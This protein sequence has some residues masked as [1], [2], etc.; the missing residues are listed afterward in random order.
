MLEYLSDA[1]D[2]CRYI[3]LYEEG[4][5][6]GYWTV[7]PDGKLQS[8]DRMPYHTDCIALRTVLAI[9]EIFGCDY[10]ISYVLRKDGREYSTAMETLVVREEQLSIYELIT[11]YLNN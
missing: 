7:T 10:T 1:K 9:S 5:D 3:D 6:M 2:W 8:W 11:L 4:E